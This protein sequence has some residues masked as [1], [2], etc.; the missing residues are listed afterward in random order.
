MDQEMLDRQIEKLRRLK[1]FGVDQAARLADAASKT[2]SG[3]DAGRKDPGKETVNKVLDAMRSSY[4]EL[5]GGI[6]KRYVSRRNSHV[7]PAPPVRDVT[8]AEIRETLE[9]YPYLSPAEVD[10][11]MRIVES[12]ASEHKAA[13][14]R[15]ATR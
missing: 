5:V 15:F 10:V 2:I 13:R 3:R 9:A 8:E 12:K 6:A 4:D 1:D 7:V 14:S 11:I